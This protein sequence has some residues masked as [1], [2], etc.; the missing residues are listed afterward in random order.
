MEPGR[1]IQRQI[2]GF[3]FRRESGLH[4]NCLRRWFEPIRDDAAADN[5]GKEHASL[6]ANE[7]ALCALGRLEHHGEY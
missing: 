4:C 2:G 7:G 6:V 3:R 5:L 1:T